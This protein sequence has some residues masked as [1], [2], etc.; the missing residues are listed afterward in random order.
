[1]KGGRR[2][3][4]RDISQEMANYMTETKNDN[5]GHGK[6]TVFKPSIA[7]LLLSIFQKNSMPDARITSNYKGVFHWVADGVFE[8]IRISAPDYNRVPKLYVSTDNGTQELSQQNAEKYDKVAN[9]MAD[10]FISKV[11]AEMKNNPIS[12]GRRKTRKHR[13]RKLKKTR[14]H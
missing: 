4:H 6:Y 11:Q 13:S 12:A 2:S 10:E 5:D 14:K 7:K 9:S 8:T 3:F 1:M